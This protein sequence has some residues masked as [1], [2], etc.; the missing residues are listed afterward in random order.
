M[1]EAH[2]NLPRLTVLSIYPTT[3]IGNVQT[4][5]L[6]RNLIHHPVQGPHFGD[7]EIEAKL[8]END[9]SRWHKM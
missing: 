6:G 4:G 3:F 2:F 7:E 8:G 5:T 1:P 9:F